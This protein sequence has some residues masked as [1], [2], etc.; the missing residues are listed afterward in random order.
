MTNRRMTRGSKRAW[1]LTLLGAAALIAAGAA[2]ALVGAAQVDDRAPEARPHAVGVAMLPRGAPVSQRKLDGSL[3]EVEQRYPE[4]GGGNALRALRALNPSARFRLLKTESIPRV[5]VDAIADRDTAALRTALERLGFMT[6][7]TFS[8][9]VGGWLPVNELANVAALAELR[10]VRASRPRTRAGAVMTQGD[11]AQR[12]D[13]VR[14]S[15]T[16]TGLTGAGV[17]VGVLSDSFN[18]Y[19]VYRA[20]GVPVT[21]AEGYAPNGI[22][23]DYAQDI[24]SADLP[25]GVAIL[26]EA[27]CLDYDPGE[28]TPFGDEGRAMLQI[29]HDIAPGAKLAFHTA[30]LSEADF[31]AGIQQLA[32]AGAR[33]IIDDV[34]YADEPVFQDGLLAQAVDEVNSG[35]KVAYF[36]AAGNDARNS[37]EISAPSFKTAAQVNEPNAG[38]ELLN[39]DASGAT[40]T[41]V[42]PVTIP[43]LQPGEF[44]NFVVEWDQPYVTGAS[45]SPGASS[46]I[47]ICII[48]SS[49]T[50]S[51]EGASTVGQDP[52]V[53]LTWLN[54]A[55][56]GANSAVEQVGIQIGLKHG[57]APHLIK[58]LVDDDGAGAMINAFQTH[59]ATLQG[60]PGAAGAIAVGAAKYL[61]TPRCGTTPAVL[62]PFSSAGGDPILFDTKGNRLAT[63]QIRNKPDLV[64][65]DGVDNTFLGVLQPPLST[66]IAECQ[67]NSAFPSFFGT[68]AAAPHAG[69][70]A[71]LLLQARPTA[72]PAQIYSALRATTLNMGSAGFDFDTGY[73]FIQ[74]DAALDELAG[75]VAGGGSAVT[76]AATSSGGGGG[77]A[78]GL[79]ELVLMG[80]VWFA[81]TRPRISARRARVGP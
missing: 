49:A 10:L 43:T 2:G 28:L 73:G 6:T 54:P 63:P 44:I 78:L 33:V 23:T 55:S 66:S 80:L 69:A 52:F 79:P 36:S 65:P 57:G 48:D 81:L 40:T 50:T 29:V 70:V 76:T 38:E 16:V 5:L 41:T 46:S 3:R 42:L 58:L 60:H 72:T 59:S 4:M 17:M 45:G 37:I 8:N 25:S 9:D 75:A 27:N 30:E 77:G 15:T 35:Q 31:A 13:L 39:F 62:E 56:S 19:P 1:A 51:C 53:I 67:N 24:A 74:A 47:D 34:G 7:A 64:A 26:E 21:G 18:C 32:G 14:A 20:N 12:S 22:T 61:A 11:F 68:S 71:A